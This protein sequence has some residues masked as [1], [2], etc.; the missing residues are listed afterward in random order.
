M[1]KTPQVEISTWRGFD[2]YA[3]PWVSAMQEHGLSFCVNWNTGNSLWH[4]RA[5]LLGAQQTPPSLL[6]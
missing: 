2:C 4:P 1:S 5:C 3:T 6:H